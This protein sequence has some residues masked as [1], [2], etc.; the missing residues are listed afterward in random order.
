MPTDQQHWPLRDHVFDIVWGAFA[1][2]NLVA[3]VA[4]PEWETVPFHFIWVSL[5]IVYGFRVWKKRSTAWALAGVTI[6]TGSVIAH[7]I[8]IGAQPVDEITEVP[9]MAAMF[10][11]MV[12]HAKRRLAAMQQV[13]Q[14]SDANRRLLE[15]EQRFVQNASHQLRTPITIALGHAELIERGSAGQPRED[16]LVVVEELL[17][18]RRLADLLLAIA[19]GEERSIGM[20]AEVDVD[21]MMAETL[22]RWKPTPR[23]WRTGELDSATVLADIDQLQLVVDELI[24][25]AVAHTEPADSITLGVRRRD[26]SVVISV[27]DSGEGIDRSDLDRIFDRFARSPSASR[28]KPSGL[29]LGLSLVK[30]VAESHGGGV[31]VRSSLGEGSVFELSLPAA[32]IRPTD[33]E[34]RPPS[35]IAARTRPT[36]MTAS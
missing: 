32:P 7:D 11:A 3:M 23:D 20:K 4:F 28:G 17:R 34:S 18:L 26:G 5:T 8:A 10:V 12:W 33:G 30:S 21:V 31:R 27:A 9:L 13:K 24:E 6:L 14:V 22:R 19:A 15:R 2:A 36:R 16:A 35:R 1:V 29:G 25:N